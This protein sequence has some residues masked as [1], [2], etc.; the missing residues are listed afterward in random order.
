MSAYSAPSKNFSITRAGHP[1]LNLTNVN[2]TTICTIQAYNSVQ[3]TK[4]QYG[5]NKYNFWGRANY[6]F[7]FDKV[8]SDWT[9]QPNANHYVHEVL[10]IYQD[11]YGSLPTGI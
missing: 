3:S 2:P 9:F 11:L 8:T 1:T 7:S 10:S 4:R 5:L 6:C